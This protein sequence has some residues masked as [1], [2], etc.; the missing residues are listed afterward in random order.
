[1]FYDNAGEGQFHVRFAFCKKE[2]VL[3][4]ALTRLSALRP[5]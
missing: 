1:V 3:K 5:G 4:E 2:E